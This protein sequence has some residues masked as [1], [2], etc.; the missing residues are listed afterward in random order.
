MV[1]PASFEEKLFPPPLEVLKTH[2]EIGARD[3]GD[4]ND[5]KPITPYERYLF[6]HCFCCDPF[7]RMVSDQL[8]S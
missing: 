4:L 1:G 7:W 3:T 6:H 8:G 5:C 2:Q